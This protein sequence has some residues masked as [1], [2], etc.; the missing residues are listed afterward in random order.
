MSAAPGKC[1]VCGHKFIPWEAW[2]ITRWS[3][4]SC[5]ACK[6]KLNREK[7]TQFFMV[8][9]LGIIGPAIC[10]LLQLSLLWFMV[11]A[12]VSAIVMYV[13]DTLTVRLVKVIPIEKVRQSET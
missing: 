2:K 5:P 3:S 8:V 11:S 1:P 6:A 12:I 9:L 7:D 13:A 10:M 4:I